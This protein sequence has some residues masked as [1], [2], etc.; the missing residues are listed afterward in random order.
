M[1]KSCKLPIF[2]FYF[3]LFCSRTW[4][5]N[6]KSDFESQTSQRVRF[7]FFFRLVR[8]WIKNFTARQILNSKTFAWSDFEINFFF[9]KSFFEGEYFFWKSNFEFEFFYKNPTLNLKLYS[10]SDFEVKIFRLVRF[11]NQFFFEKLD[12][13]EEIYFLEV[14]FWLNFFEKTRFW[15]TISIWKNHVFNQFTP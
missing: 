9:E 15:I 7:E 3:S 2:F 4:K 11:W 13:A 12:F 8:F 14:S 1:Q 5:T 10:A 6:K